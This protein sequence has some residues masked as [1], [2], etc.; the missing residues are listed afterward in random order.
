MKIPL[1]IIITNHSR[2]KAK[3]MNDDDSRYVQPII[4]QHL[5]TSIQTLF[6]I[7]KI[8][9]WGMGFSEK[10]YTMMLIHLGCLYLSAMLNLL[11]NNNALSSLFE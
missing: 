2:S 3:R 11:D 8:Q 1:G 10:S 9:A 4:M 5:S 6:C 7:S